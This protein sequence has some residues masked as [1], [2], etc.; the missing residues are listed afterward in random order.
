MGGARGRIVL[1]GLLDH[2]PADGNAG[3]GQLRMTDVCA[4]TIAGLCFCAALLM[5][6]N[7]TLVLQKEA[8]P[9]TISVFASPE[10]LRIGRGDLSVM[11]QKS[12]G[13]SSVLDAKVKLHLTHSG[14]EGISEVFVPATHGKASNK[15]LYASNVN[16]SAEGVWNLMVTVESNLGN[17]EVAGKITV[18]PR[19]APMA[20]YWPYFAVVPLIAVLFVINQ[21]LRR[22]RMI[23]PHPRARA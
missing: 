13:R 9:F 2:I 5:A 7:G 12:A 11:L 18:G 4:R 17:A 15:L 1:I 22:K 14:A 8:G 10:P 16:L 20:A 19:Q 6:D 3:H 23:G 21:W